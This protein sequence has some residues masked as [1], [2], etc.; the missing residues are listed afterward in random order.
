VSTSYSTVSG[1]TRG[2]SSGLSPRP[3]T[4]TQCFGHNR[5][6]SV[7]CDVNSATSSPSA[8]SSG[9]AAQAAPL[10]ALQI[11]YSLIE[12]TVE[13]DLIPMAA[14]LGLGGIPWSPLASGVLAG[15]YSRADLD[16][17]GCS[18]EAMGTRKN[19]AAANGALSERGLAIADAVK[20][21][22]ADIGTPPSRVALAWTM[23]NPA[24]TAPIIGARTPAQLMD[25]LGALEVRIPDDALASLEEASDIQLGFPHEF[26]AR[27]TTRNNIFGDIKLETG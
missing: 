11:E 12:R 17:G 22:A 7:L 23:H 16:R 4:L 9:W 20:N 6:N 1:P 14:E 2:C 24:V 5:A 25:N 15:K 18:A 21:V 13:R 8:A 10:V 26:L 27:P 19:M 3:F